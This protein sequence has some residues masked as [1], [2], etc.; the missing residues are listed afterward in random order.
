MLPDL[1]CILFSVVRDYTDV[2][3]LKKQRN[4]SM[5]NN[6]SKQMLYLKKSIE[7]NEIS[8]LLGNL[9]NSES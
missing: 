1:P 2:K 8:C 3:K 7:I 6:W 4:D 9:Q 5:N